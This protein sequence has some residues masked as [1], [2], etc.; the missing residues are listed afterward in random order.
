MLEDRYYMRRSPFEVR[1]SAAL[2]LV[3]IN[4]LAYVLQLVLESRVPDTFYYGALSLEGLKHGYLWQLLSFQFMHANLMHL[5]G[6]C[7]VIYVFGRATEEALGRRAFWTLYFA[8]GVIGGMIQ[9]LAGLA[10]P[11]AFGGP[12]LGASAGAFGLTA[13]FA[14]LFPDQTILL[15]FIIP[16]R[17]RFLLVIEGVVAVLGLLGYVS[18]GVAHAAH[19]GGM[20]T[21]MFFVRYAIHW[22]WEWPQLRRPRR[23]PPRRLVRVSSGSSAL[24]NRN[25]DTAEDLPPEEFLSKEVDPILDKIS[26]QGIHSLTERERRIL[27]AARQKMGKR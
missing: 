15:F 5:L 7:F 10:M 26:A 13:A 9:V 24:W 25:R 23:E 1:R 22:H 6:N 20:L 12:V 27:E 17:A 3:I 4:I 14:M 21:G 2:M 16:L 11:A 18:P 8:S 19:L